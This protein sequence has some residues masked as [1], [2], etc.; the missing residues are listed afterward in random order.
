MVELRKNYEDNVTELYTLNSTIYNLGQFEKM[1]SYFEVE[2]LEDYQ[3]FEFDLSILDENW[4]KE[5]KL[6]VGVTDGYNYNE[7]F[8][9]MTAEEKKMFAYQYSKGGIAAAR[10]FLKND[11]DAINSRVGY[12][13]ALEFVEWISDKTVITRQEYIDKLVAQGATLEEAREKANGYPEEISLVDKGI[14]FLFTGV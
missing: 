2:S 11:A 14:D 1:I 7:L 6:D 4:L 10:E 3:K 8:L 13:N 9:N 5:N 12:N